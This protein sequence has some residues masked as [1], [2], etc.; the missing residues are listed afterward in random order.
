MTPS[1]LSRRPLECI[2]FAALVLVSRLLFRSHVLYDLDS[3]NFA[4][5]VSRFDPTVHQPHPPGY[6]LYICLARVVNSIV[7]DPNTALVAIGIAASCGAVVM[8]Y[9]LAFEW[10]G[11][12]AARFA[13]VLF[14]F[15]PLTWFHGIVGLI[16]IVEAFLSAL[17]GY[18]C[19]QVY[20]GRKGFAIPAALV[21]GLG[22]GIRPS[23][24]VFLAPL[25]LLSLWGLSWKRAGAV[26]VAALLAVLA[27]F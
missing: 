14:L 20:M 7:H 26:I 25:F 3:V 22:A 2:L 18:F 4:L 9:L 11:R 17:A 24:P 19:W 27:W 13:A 12:D 10:F 8:I 6:F 1:V 5:G 23:F 15:S 21:L 16:Y